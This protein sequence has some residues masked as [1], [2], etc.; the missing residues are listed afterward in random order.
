MVWD[1]TTRF[2]R[3]LEHIPDAW[4]WALAEVIDTAET[5]CIGLQQSEFGFSNPA[6]EC[7]QLVA[8]LTRLAF[9]RRYGTVSCAHAVPPD[10]KY[11]PTDDC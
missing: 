4:R 9:E 6:K 5:V 7:P 3:R 8:D 11:P 1:A 10:S 2:D